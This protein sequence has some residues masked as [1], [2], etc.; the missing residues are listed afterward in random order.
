VATRRFEDPHRVATDGGRQDLA[1]GVRGQ[2]RAREPWDAVV[3]PLRLEQALPAPRHRRHGHQHH[4]RRAEERP[5][6]RIGQ[7]LRRLRQVDLP[8][9]VRDREARHDEGR[10]DPHAPLHEK[11]S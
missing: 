9:E 11:R 4:G 1:G 5:G 6:I 10:D 3:D 8:D 7:R 2:V